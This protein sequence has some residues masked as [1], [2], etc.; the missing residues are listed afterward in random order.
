MTSLSYKRRPDGWFECDMCGFVSP[1]ESK[2]QRHMVKSHGHE[3][4]PP[5]PIRMEKWQ[6]A[7]AQAAET[8]VAAVWAVDEEE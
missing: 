3:P 7:E 6:I 8:D 4:F 2:M 1:H 5:P